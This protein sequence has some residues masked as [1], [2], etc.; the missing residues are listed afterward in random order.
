MRS[1]LYVGATLMIGASIYGFVDYKKTSQK[2]EF[3]NMYENQVEKSPVV[4]GEKKVKE[5]INT[6]TISEKREAKKA[7]SK[8]EELAPVKTRSKDFVTPVETT[9]L[10]TE[11]SVK[12]DELK[13]IKSVKKIKSAKPK[14]LNYK[15]FSR[16][17]LE[18]R[19][20]E[21]TLKLE[22]PKAKVE[23]KKTEDK[24]Q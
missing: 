24:D 19:Y 3:T 10:K 22:E 1:I 8:P 9:G 2:K 6:K 17:S 11:A 4:S 21:K 16:G 15:L 12:T 13:E 5:E 18:E 14:K 23:P 20:V 7:E